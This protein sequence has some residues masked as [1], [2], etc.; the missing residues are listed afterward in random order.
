MIARAPRGS[1]VRFAT[2][3]PDR[4]DKKA[5]LSDS[6][7]DGDE[8][9][10][11]DEEEQKRSS[12]HN[13][14]RRDSYF[15]R[16]GKRL[17]RHPH[18]SASVFAVT[19]TLGYVTPDAKSQEKLEEEERAAAEKRRLSRSGSNGG[20]RR[21][22]VSGL[23]GGGTM[24]VSG[25]RSRSLIE[26]LETDDLL[27]GLTKESATKGKSGHPHLLRYARK[28]S[29]RK[30][31]GAM[32]S[33]RPYGIDE[34]VDVDTAIIDGTNKVAG[35]TAKQHEAI[36]DGKRDSEDDGTGYGTP[37]KKANGNDAVGPLSSEEM[38][39]KQK[40]AAATLASY[41]VRKARK[42]DDTV[43]RQR[44]LLED[45]GSIDRFGTK[46]PLIIKETESTANV[47][48][49]AKDQQYHHH[50]HSPRHPH[51]HYHQQQQ[52]QQQKQSQKK[53]E[54][55]PGKTEDRGATIRDE[56]GATMRAFT[57]LYFSELCQKMHLLDLDERKSMISYFEAHI[58]GQEVA[59]PVAVGASS[60][61]AAPPVNQDANVDSSYTG[62]GLYARLAMPQ[63][64]NS[65]HGNMAGLYSFS[66]GA[67]TGT[68]T[69]SAEAAA[70]VNTTANKGRTADIRHTISQVPKTLRPQD[71]DFC[72]DGMTG[73][74]IVM[75]MVTWTMEGGHKHS[76]QHIAVDEDDEK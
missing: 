62:N 46:I 35:L 33:F 72:L 60:A 58:D 30:E 16:G 20:R 65:L 55:G 39:A 25:E 52:Q 69:T 37:E 45:V 75:H 44:K 41:R 22:S 73:E 31:D 27:K 66:T 18:F 1:I 49:E 50:K 48:D 5:P 3:A 28:Q 43:M 61:S 56:T 40:A 71:F 74:E 42:E 9:L 67:A 12:D 38:K 29:I 53:Q 23:S 64:R 4:M 32:P 34:E 17:L 36:I 70:A 63:H 13:F 7:G 59:N 24:S 6:D 76:E 26:V 8:D 54:Q 19:E 21:S 15:T 68:A 51:T 11:N 10:H 2:P 57:G 14:L 47:A